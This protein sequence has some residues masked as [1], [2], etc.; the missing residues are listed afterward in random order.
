MKAFKVIASIG[1]AAALGFG[2]T[3]CAALNYNGEGVVVSKNIEKDTKK[4]STGKKKSKTVT[5]HK[6][7][8]D[9]PDTDI[10]RSVKVDK[11]KYDKIKVGDK[12][13]IE[14]NKLK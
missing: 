10:D 13:V 2:M 4:S 6:I 8:V 12:V 3:S 14:G 9:V 11:A 5:E 1:V 7:V